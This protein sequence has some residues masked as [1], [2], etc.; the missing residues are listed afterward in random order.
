MNVSH[1]STFYYHADANAIGG[2]LK[3]PLERIVS[4]HASVSLAQAGGFSAATAEKFHVDDLISV[5]MAHAHVAGSEHEGRGYR[6]TA[7]AT[8]ENLNVLEVITADRIVAQVSIMHPYENRPAEISFIGTQFVNLRVNGTP[9][10][11]VLD[12][13]LF[14]AGRVMTEENAD[15][16]APSFRE[17]SAVAESQYAEGADQRRLIVDTLGERFAFVDPRQDLDE[18]G[19]ALCSLVQTVTVDEPIQGFGHVIHV[20]DFGNIFLGELCVGRFSA[21]LT[22]LRVELG[23]IAQGSVA[24]GSVRSNGRLMP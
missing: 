8:V 14:G 2:S 6:S 4:S 23:C 24:A 16:H 22:M 7:T 9:V 11:P 13:K 12:R 10:A 15:S 19:S 21:E 1:K 17:L 3:Q 20:P 5:G 18:K